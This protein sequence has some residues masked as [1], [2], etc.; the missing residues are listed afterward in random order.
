MR[1]VI[2]CGMAGFLLAAGMAS[3]QEAGPYLGAQGGGVFPSD[4]ESA[5]AY[6]ATAGYSFG[7]GLRLELD[8][9]R[10]RTSFDSFGGVPVTGRADTTTIMLNGLYG[11]GPGELKPYLGAGVGAQDV[12]ARVPGSEDHAWV[13]AYQLRGG[14]SYSFTQK[15]FGSLEYRWENGK[16]P[17]LRLSGIPAKLEIK[18]HGIL[19]GLNYHL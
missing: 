13:P 18:R 11:F 2:A 3:A 6:G 8:G 4:G 10:A 14:V 12:S 1:R 15:I 7:T 17:N 19:V 9:L 5:G 16:A